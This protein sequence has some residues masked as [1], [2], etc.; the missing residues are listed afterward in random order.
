M[1]RRTIFSI[2]RPPTS[3]FT[4]LNA[5]QDSPA[6][7]LVWHVSPLVSSRHASTELPP[8]TIVLEKPDKFRPPSHP[9]RLNK[10][11]PRQ[12]PGPP[13]SEPEREA[14]K[15][16]RYPHM[17]PNE[18]TTL[19]WFLTNKWI[20]M[21]ISLGT[22]SLLAVI[23]L[24]QSFLLT[25]PFA[26]L[27]PPISSLPLH[28]LNYVSEWL[29]TI[30][31]HVDYNSQKTA[32]SRA[33]GILDAQKRRLYRRAHGMEDLDAEEEQGID[34]RGLVPWDDGLTNKERAQGGRFE[35][36]TGK[37]VLEAGGEVGDSLDADPVSPKD[38]TNP[39]VQTM[40]L[41]P[42]GSAEQEH[43]QMKERFDSDEPAKKKKVKRWLG[44][45]E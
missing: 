11:P 3:R 36:R 34:V 21:W 29:S 32:E 27:A 31:L 5:L 42:E 4:V 16:R 38:S 33:N 28:P 45:W 7:T 10:R 24:T 8:K 2:I 6:N 43:S 41:A 13:L 17:F 37:Q 30:R 19:H 22:L 23:T 1:S 25:S 18:G 39:V 12:Y 15:T 20:H 40:A 14:Q 26:H 35:R 9:Q 44:I